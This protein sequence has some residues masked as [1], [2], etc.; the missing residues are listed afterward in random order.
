SKTWPRWRDLRRRGDSRHAGTSRYR[1]NPRRA[2]PWNLEVPDRAGTPIAMSAPIA[3]APAERV[4]T[5]SGV[6]HG[7]IAGATWSYLGVPYAAPPVGALRLAP[8]QPVA[9]SATELDA[10]K[11]G[12]SCAQLD[13]SG[14][15]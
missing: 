4:A 13:A 8:T 11:L 9:C 6:V 3:G 14:N 15:V 10:T 2:R 12:P 7:A 1:A 5:T